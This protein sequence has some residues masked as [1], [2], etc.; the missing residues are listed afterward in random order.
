MRNGWRRHWIFFRMIGSLSKKLL[1]DKKLEWAKNRDTNVLGKPLLYNASQQAKYQKSIQN[2][3]K[4]MT[5]ETMEQTQKL[6]HGEIADDYFEQQAQAAAL[7]ASITNAAKKLMNKLTAKFQ[8]LFNSKAEGLAITM[9]NGAKKTSETNLHS[10]LKQLSGGL[11]LKTGIVP[12]GMEDVANASIQENVA[13]IKSIPGRYLTDVQGA[14]MRSI[15]TGAGLADLIPAI[16]KYNGITMRRARFI[17]QDQTRKAYNSINKQ[18][19]QAIG[20][21]QFKWLHSGGGREPRRSHLAMSGN[22]YSFDD[23]PQINKD[24]KGQPP[25]YGIPGQ[26]PGCRCTMNPIISFDSGE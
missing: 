20:V 24:N 9:V 3:V 18:R 22:I 8:Q 19:L 26:A 4:Q 2:L 21:K 12:K 16:S 25:E 14:V 23:L 15:T 1:T 11:S 17:A 5:K 13:L 7:D 6:F 10:S